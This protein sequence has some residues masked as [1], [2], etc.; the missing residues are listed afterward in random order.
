MWFPLCRGIKRADAVRIF[1]MYHFGGI[2]ADLDS[3]CLRPF[4]TLFAE[5]RERADVLLGRLK[6]VDAASL[7]DSVPLRLRESGPSTMAARQG[8][9]NAIMVSKPRARFW[10]GRRP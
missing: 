2:Y 4:E 9:P 6:G 7:A 1:Y 3:V 10:N 8:V 5:H